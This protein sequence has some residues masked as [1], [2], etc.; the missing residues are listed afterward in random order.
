MTSLARADRREINRC[1]FA[2]FYADQRVDL[3]IEES[4]DS[5]AS[6]PHGRRR[7][8]QV[9]ADVA[10]VEV[11]I[12]VG[13]LAVFLSGTSNNRN[14][15]E[16][17]GCRPGHF[18]I[19]RRMGDLLRKIP[20]FFHFQRKF[21]Q[22]QGIYSRVQILHLMNHQIG[23]DGMERSGGGGG[24]VP[25]GRRIPGDTL[26]RPEKV[27]QVLE[28][29]G[30][31][32]VVTDG[33]AIFENRPKIRTRLGKAWGK[34]DNFGRTRRRNGLLIPRPMSRA[35][36]FRLFLKSLSD[37]RVEIFHVPPGKTFWSQCIPQGADCQLVLR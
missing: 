27:C 26:S 14:P 6:Q 9:L 3:F 29:E 24:S 18:L 35:K 33:A 31:R 2:S 12:A 11:N 13:S 20:A 17:D 36:V 32:K 4:G 16:N 30:D 7:K 8:I 21:R 37:F 23:V 22:P 1:L 5:T 10:A 28:G 15:N 34:T 19:E 25:R